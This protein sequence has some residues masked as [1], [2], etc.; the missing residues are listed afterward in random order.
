MSNIDPAGP[1]MRLLRALRWEHRASLSARGLSGVELVV[2]DAHQ[3]LRGPSPQSRR[4]QQRCRTHFMTNLLTRVPRRAQKEE[5]EATH[6]ED[7]RTGEGRRRLSVCARDLYRLVDR[8]HG[9]TAAQLEEYRLLERLL[10]EQCHVG[11][12]QDGRPRDD[13]DDAGECKVPVA[14]KDPEAG[15]RRLAAIAPHGCDLHILTFRGRGTR[16][17]WR[18]PATRR[19]PPMTHHPRGGDP[20]EWERHRRERAGR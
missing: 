13:D 2:S 5:D 17:R 7:A 15:V 20:L 3:G 12:H 19:T 10:R 11:K 8:F 9:T 14:L 4:S 1:S 6:Y 16:C 18:R